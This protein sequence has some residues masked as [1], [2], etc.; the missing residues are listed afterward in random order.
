MTMDVRLRI[1]PLFSKSFQIEKYLFEIR[2]ALTERVY[3][4]AAPSANGSSR[5]DGY[6][7][8]AKIVSV[9]GLYAEAGAVMI[10]GTQVCGLRS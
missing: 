10:F 8:E 1:R 5:W 7:G 6:S 3:G 9:S 4:S 2:V